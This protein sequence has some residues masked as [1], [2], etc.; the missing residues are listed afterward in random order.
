MDTA[1][2]PGF[3]R[4]LSGSMGNWKPRNEITGIANLLERSGTE[5]IQK[6]IMDLGEKKQGS[7]NVAKRSENEGVSW[8]EIAQEKKVLKKYDL[9]IE[10]LEGGKAVEI[11][12]EVIEQADLLWDD[13]LIGKFLDTAPHVARVHAIVNRIWNQGEMKQQIDVQVGDDTTMKSK[14]LNP[15]M[16]AR[17]V[18][19]GMWNIGN[20]PLVVMKW[21]LDDLKE[22]P[23]IK[24]IPMWVYLKN[25]PMNMY[26][27]RGLSFIVSAAG[28]PV[29]L[30]PETASCSNFKLAKIFVNVDLSKELPDKINF[31]KKG[32]S[33]LVEFIYP[34]LPLRCSTCGKWGHVEKVCVMNKKDGSE[35]SVTQ[36]IHEDTEKRVG[37]MEKEKEDSK[38]KEKEMEENIGSTKKSSD[39][40]TIKEMEVEEG[41]IEE[42][43]QDVTPKKA[44]RSSTLKFGQ[45]KI[46]TPS[47]FPNLLEVDEKGDVINV[48]ET[49]EI[50]SVVEEIMEEG[51][52]T[53]RVIEENK[54]K[55]KEDID[56]E[57]KEN[58]CEMQKEENKFEENQNQG[59]AGIQITQENWP[60]L[61]SASKIRPSLPRRSKTLHRAV[62]VPESFGNMGKRNTV[63]ALIEQLIDR[64]SGWAQLG[65]WHIGQEEDIRQA[66]ELSVVKTLL[67]V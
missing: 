34:W 31:T 43:W 20:V 60:D 9:K 25:V 66:L 38:S 62:Q 58:D 52:D 7:E 8:A 18:Q 24:S 13:Y 22:K 39:L 29:R 16:R 61:A 67:R 45:V 30:H 37:D 5:K 17:I 56:A 12:D 35:K 3:S 32:K 14:V 47:R 10:D 54:E 15:V 2:P 65:Y 42:N 48:V 44:S 55:E 36:I 21:T 64:A 46:L 27:W 51:V 6:E 23:E 49:E 57:R 33:H 53:E 11:P 59:I 50:L 40:E 28:F 19:R 1:I 63:E 4:S 26:S 41:E